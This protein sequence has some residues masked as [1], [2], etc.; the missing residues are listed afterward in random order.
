MKTLN[1]TDLFK[2][3]QRVAGKTTALSLSV[4]LT[5][6]SLPVYGAPNT[7][8]ADAQAAE[9]VSD[10]PVQV[11]YP[12]GALLIGSAEELI[13]FAQNCSLDS[14]STGLKVFLTNDIRM[15]YDE[16]SGIPYF[17]GEFDGGGHVVDGVSITAGGSTRGFF[18]YVAKG[19]TVKN[20]TV[21]GVIRPQGTKAT[22][23]G[24]VADNKG[25]IVGCRFNGTIEGKS[26][27]GGIAG[28]NGETGQIV[29]CTSWGSITGE[30][31]TGGIC[32][33]NTGSITGSAN[34]AR[35]N[36][37]EVEVTLDVSD[38][39]IRKITD[40]ETNLTCTDTGGIAGYSSGIIRS[41]SNRGTVGYPHTGYNV[42]GIAGRQSGFMSECSNYGKIY[43]RKEVAGIVGQA[44]PYVALTYNQSILND[45]FDEFDN[46]QG[47]LGDM[48]D[49]NTD[50]PGD[51]SK[52]LDSLNDSLT[53]AK[54]STKE[55]IDTVS[56]W[57]DESID[58]INDAIS[59]VSLVIDNVSPAVTDL[60]VALDKL[61]RACDYLDDALVNSEEA[62][63]ILTDS[64]NLEDALNSIKTVS[65]EAESALKDLSD[66]MQ[67]LNA[68]LGDADKTSDA[69]DDI[70]DALKALSK[71]LDKIDTSISKIA[72]LIEIPDL[73]GL[74]AE[75]A[76]NL[77]IDSI[78]SDFKA[79]KKEFKNIAQNVSKANDALTLILDSVSV[80]T[81]ELDPKMLRTSL[82]TMSRAFDTL[83]NTS[84]DINAA[85]DSMIA[86][87]SDLKEAGGAITDAAESMQSVTKEFQSAFDWFTKA[88]DRLKNT[89]DELTAMPD[90]E[91]SK[92]GDKVSSTSDSLNQSVTEMQ[93]IL[94]SLN[95]LVTGSSDTMV[96]DLKGINNKFS[97]IISLFR[98]ANDDATADKTVDDVYED[99]SEN[100]TE[101]SNATGKVANCYNYGTVEGDVNIGG[102][103]GSMA[104]ERDFDPEDD[105]QKIGNRSTD[106]VFRTRTVLRDCEN[107]GEITAKKNAAGSIVGRMDI[108]M[109]ID[110]VGYGTV[111]ST[112]GDYVGGIVGIS[113]TSVFGCKAKAT[114]SGRRYVGGIAGMGHDVKNC[115]SVP[116]V[117]EGEQFVGA[118]VGDADGD[119]LSNRFVSREIAGWDGVSYAGKAEP[120]TYD[121][122]RAET[123]LPADFATETAVFKAEDTV[124]ARINYN[125]GEPIPADR[126]PAVPSKDG[127]EGKWQ[128][129][130]GALTYG[131]I[132]EAEYNPFVTA[133][134]ATGDESMPDVLLDGS[135]NTTALAEITAFDGSFA[136]LPETK[137]QP[138][139]YS[140]TISGTSCGLDGYRV[141]VK[142]PDTFK[143]TGVYLFDGTKWEKADS[144][145]DGSY[146][147]FDAQGET[148]S[149]ALIET[150][151]YAL[152]NLL[153]AA[154][155]LVV[156]V[157]ILLVVRKRNKAKKAKKASTKAE[158]PDKKK[159]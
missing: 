55:L 27:V 122:L 74:T 143:K 106:F 39:D 118:I 112:G 146:L 89:A 116:A 94:S 99:I 104:I 7:G 59:R 150:H 42:G 81:G 20:L 44:E 117:D 113:Y 120:M 137:S 18:R 98:K 50:L 97:D 10:A 57:G 30:Y 64:Q 58:S 17:A 124:V 14:Y 19:A 87:S 121:Q 125:Y 149:F 38:F 155:I 66:A 34:H 46:L 70:T 11:V 22:V 123:G 48:L 102:I 88:S 144:S 132:I 119:V 35:V 130:G 131:R 40:A 127:Y 28:L 134:Q 100:D 9:T 43:G 71:A 93:D 75:E 105:L 154:G 6:G 49:H 148:V 114:L 41:C 139:A 142:K 86:S 12:E 103:A 138:L 3:F 47:L 110:C 2:N 140:F 152:W 157:V 129:D 65:T 78:T 52:H 136:G 45:I 91:F 72:D 33:K 26:D 16:F 15:D 36:T 141:R 13:A 8:A 51:I 158:K 145:E 63:R 73:S 109:V 61:S 25:T 128:Y 82:T 84:D 92:I 31:R 24:I 115:I 107:R 156:L 147:V 133:L 62:V 1:K 101:S 60:Q 83:A 111:T 76:L 96:S 68:A 77:D 80:I 23:G 5:L 151:N 153:L 79:F 4:L 21:R 108:G 29:D 54:D 37:V 126:I 135:F 69:L 67:A 85:L 95:N 90:I 159:A 53:G 32:G 56:D